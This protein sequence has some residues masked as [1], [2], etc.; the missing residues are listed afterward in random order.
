MDVGEQGGLAW[1]V[2]RLE[3][4]FWNPNYK[5]C[6]SLLTEGVMVVS[7]SGTIGMRSLPLNLFQPNRPTDKVP[8]LPPLKFLQQNRPTGKVLY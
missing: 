4:L 1:T 8:Y 3:I 2:K 6:D 5:S 7:E